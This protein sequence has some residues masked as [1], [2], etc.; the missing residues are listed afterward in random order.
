MGMMILINH[1]EQEE[2]E[3]IQ[4]Y[5]PSYIH[6]LLTVESEESNNVKVPLLQQSCCLPPSSFADPVAFVSL[7]LIPGHNK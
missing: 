6:N 1:I 3:Y 4:I 7:L 5:N 2:D